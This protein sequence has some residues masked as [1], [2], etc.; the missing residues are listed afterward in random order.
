VNTGA[1]L[2]PAGSETLTTA[3]LARLLFIASRSRPVRQ[4]A[5]CFIGS[6]GIECCIPH[7]DERNF[8][9]LIDN[10]R[11][12]VRHTVR[13]QHTIRLR[14]GTV[15]EIAEEGES[16]FQLFGENFLGGRVVCTNAKYLGVI[17]FEFCDTSLVRGEFLR[18]ATGESGRKECHHH[19]AFAFEIG[20]RDFT[21]HGGTES[22]AGRDVANLERCGI[23]GLLGEHRRA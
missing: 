7:I 13:T 20:Q 12:A 22:K 17:A 16:Q 6:G 14:G 23:A 11:N 18:S 4:P 19:W 8:P 1:V 5:A 9:V 15:F 2:Y 3:P 21:A 10:V